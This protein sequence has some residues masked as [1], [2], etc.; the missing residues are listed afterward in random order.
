MN[1][2]NEPQEWNI[3]PEQRGGGDGNKWNYALLVPL[4]GLAAFRWIW[5]RESRKEVQVVKDQY[6]QNMAAVQADMEKKYQQTLRE[7]RKETVQLELELEREKKR[8]Q[9][10]RQAMASQT[11]QFQ[12]A[13]QRLRVDRETLTQDKSHLQH[14]GAASA[15]LHSA[16]ERE[17]DSSWHRGAQATLEE[18]KEAL[19]SRQEIFCSRRTPRQK[20][21]EIEKDV[22]VRAGKDQGVLGGLNMEVGLRDIFENDRS[23]APLL[24]TDRRN[25][26]SLMW[27]YLRHWRL[28]VDLE[29]H[30][31]AEEAL[32]RPTVR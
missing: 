23:C 32:L 15:A 22:L 12:E 2:L 6:D 9:G 1:N 25:N 17:G 13:R 24:N 20:R 10:Y 7:S 8:T 18:M 21:L 31:R 5:S 28:Q 27:V 11:Q 4:F 16:L 29:K 14:R 30:R 3:R 26:G 19:M